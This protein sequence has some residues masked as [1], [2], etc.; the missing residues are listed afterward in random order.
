MNLTNRKKYAIPAGP[1]A[2]LLIILFFHPEGLSREANAVLASTVWIAIWWITEAISIYA[3]SLLPIVLFPLSGGLDLSGTTASYGHPYIFLYMG[4]FMVAIAIEKW[5]LHRRIALSII[6]LI[7]TNI[8]RIILGF[9]LATAFISM[10]I[11]NTAT[12]V[13]M[14]PIGS[15]IITQLTD[16]LGPQHSDTT[17]FGKVIM[18]SIA[19]SASIGGMATLIGTPPNLVFAGFV[20]KTYGVEITFLQWLKFGLPICLALLFIS[21][22]YL[23]SFAFRFQHKALPGGKEEIRKMLAELGKIGYEEKIVLVVFVCTAL[24][25]IFRALI[26]KIIPTL[27]DSIIAMVAGISLFLLPAKEKGKRIL[28]WHDAHKMQWGIFLLF[29]GGMAL[30]EGFKVSGLASWIAG[31]MTAMQGLTIL[32]LVIVL[33]TAVN[34]LTEI[35]SNLATTAMLLPI[36][37]SIAM[38]IH[39]H[40]FLLM[41]S[42]TIAASCA[43][44][45]PVA[46]P[47]NAI[48][49][50]SGHLK[51]PDMI[52]A[53][54]WMNIISIIVLTIFVYFILPHLWGF[55]PGGFLL[56]M[57]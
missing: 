16:K 38:A 34:F 4:G 35:T 44:M 33:I 23:T 19:Y 52:R 26:E 21:W 13:M 43:F 55:E 46:T 53:G 29:G 31:Q 12:A 36:A 1:L 39:V 48:V 17:S 11:S 9:M 15:A 54:F 49:F 40:P 22:K 47:P 18:L 10:W 3:T 7:G 5:E 27:D 20:Q 37:A 6:S 14:L 28:H 56:N 41:V 8:T 42:V 45:L 25:W 2:F 50:S 32:V 51:I 30:A 57:K 24:L